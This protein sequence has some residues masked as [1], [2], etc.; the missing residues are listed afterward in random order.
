[1]KLEKWALIAEIIGGIAVVVTLVFLVLGI[2]ENT[3][4]TRAS[5]YQTNM[6]SLNE[7]RA[8]LVT[9]DL[10]EAWNDYMDTGV[11]SERQAD[12]G[13]AN[14]MLFAIFEKSFYAKEYGI[15]GDQEWGR[16]EEQIC[17]R[18]NQ[19]TRW[20]APSAFSREILTDEFVDYIEDVCEVSD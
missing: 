16:F 11:T 20:N 8:L 6:D 10:N 13:V 17:L 3:A 9:E 18:A 2:R 12:I 4:I 14:I 19:L 5:A 7:W 1:M 15:L